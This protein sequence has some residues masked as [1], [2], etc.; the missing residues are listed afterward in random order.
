MIFDID[1]V[2]NGFLVK[3]YEADKADRKYYVFETKDLIVK[4]IEKNLKGEK[5]AQFNNPGGWL[6]SLE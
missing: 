1:K 2:E 6:S 4:F 3:V 5:N